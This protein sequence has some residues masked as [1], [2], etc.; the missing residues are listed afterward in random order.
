ML[1]LTVTWHYVILPFVNPLM[2]QPS[3]HFHARKLLLIRLFGSFAVF[4]DVSFAFIP[5]ILAQ[6]LFFLDPPS[7]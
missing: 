7:G 6:K 5:D 2:A 1:L 3:A 4:D